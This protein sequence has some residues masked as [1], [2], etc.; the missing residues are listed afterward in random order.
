M[1]NL[2]SKF[3]SVTGVIMGIA[4]L[5]SLVSEDEK[6]ASISFAIAFFTMSAYAIGCWIEEE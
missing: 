2:K 1:G 3:L 6:I 4:A 5:I